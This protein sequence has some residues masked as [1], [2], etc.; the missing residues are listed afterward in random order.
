MPRFRLEHGRRY[1]AAVKCNELEKRFVSMPT[2]M[3]QIHASGF[4]GVEFQSVRGG[5]V[6]TATYQGPSGVAAMPERI[7]RL[8]LLSSPRPSGRP[9]TP[10]P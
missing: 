10:G 6:V 1:Q 8:R 2:M 9:G 3:A 5:Y 7:V 4:G